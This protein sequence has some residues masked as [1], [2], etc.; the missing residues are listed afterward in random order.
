MEKLMNINEVAEY[1]RAP[2]ETLRWWR[3]QGTGPQGFKLGRRI[4]YREADVEAWVEQR[5]KAEAT[6]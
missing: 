6:G 3:M 2:V 4:M 1:L 5:F